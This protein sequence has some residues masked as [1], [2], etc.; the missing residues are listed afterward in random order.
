MQFSDSVSVL[1]ALADVSRLAIVNSLTEKPQYVEELSERL[2]LAASTV[3]F[4]LKKLEAAGVVTKK[5]E[6]YY[7]IY[8]INNVIMDM[9]LRSLASYENQGRDAQD[10]RMR[11][12]REKVLRTFFENGRLLRLPSQRKK[13]LIV[14]EQIAAIFEKHRVYTENEVNN[15]MDEIFD[16]HCTVRRLLIDE[17]LLE[18]SG[19]RY[20]R[21]EGKDIEEKQ[22]PFLLSGQEQRRREP[23]NESLSKQRRRELRNEYK[24]NIPS[25]GIYK[26][27]NRANGRVFIGAALNLHGIFTRHRFELDLGSHRNSD[28]QKDWNEAGA[29]AFSF[30][31]L[32]EL[33]PEPD[34]NAR[35][36]QALLDELKQKWRERLVLRPEDEYGTRHT[37]PDTKK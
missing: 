9:S 31:V 19:G 7:V 33:E 15:I 29:D 36:N 20:R 25:M 5:K 21:T 1:K 26:I 24:Q 11:R 6:Q 4:H 8:R 37:T 22:L 16:D 2:G 23:K 35:E 32:E 28:L 14:L 3:S 12:Y 10:E 30:E 18:R 13:R 17:N 27:R 34:S